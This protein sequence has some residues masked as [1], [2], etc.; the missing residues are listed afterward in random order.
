MI[1]KFESDERIF[2][3]AN[4]QIGLTEPEN[5]I[6]DVDFEADVVVNVGMGT[7]GK[8]MEIRQTLL[9]MDRAIMANQAMIPLLQSGIAPPE[10]IK[11]FNIAK[12]MEDILPK[13]GKKNVQDYFIMIQPPQLPQQPGSAPLSPEVAGRIQP[14]MGE[15]EA[16]S[17]LMKRIPEIG[18]F[19]E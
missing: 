6:M 8:E 5:Q 7:V 15:R 1:Q 16:I 19:N 14:Q 13:L 11:L 3:I 9:A 10:G 18:E 2:R 12:F 4:E 17:E